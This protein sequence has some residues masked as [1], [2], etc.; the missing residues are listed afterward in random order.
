MRI[1]LRELLLVMI[2]TGSVIGFLVDH[3]HHSTTIFLKEDEKINWERTSGGYIGRAIKENAVVIADNIYH[4]SNAV[5][6]ASTW[7]AA[8]T[9]PVY[10]FSTNGNSI[11]Y[12]NGPSGTLRWSTE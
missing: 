1:S 9:M 2:T 7:T 8:T 5:H 10:T 6:Y 3:Y 11:L 12:G 4:P